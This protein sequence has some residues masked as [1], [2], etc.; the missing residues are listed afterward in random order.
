MF[1]F[2]SRSLLAGP[3]VMEVEQDAVRGHGDD[4]DDDTDDHDDMGDDDADDDH[5]GATDDAALVAAARADPRAFASR[6]ARYVTPVYRYCYL[7]LG[8]PAAA[9]DATGEVFVKALAG[10]PD[11]RDGSFAAWLFRIARNAVA[12]TYRRSRPTVTLDTVGERA[13]R[14]PTP[15]EAML[16]REGLEALRAALDTLPIS[17][18]RAVELQVAGWSLAES[19]AALHVSVGAV[20]LLRYRALGRLKT[21]L[22]RSGHEGSSPPEGDV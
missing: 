2:R 10:L 22:S 17:Q 6:Y 14:D 12:D 20:K 7:R 5:D 16:L 4:H 13:D 8:E 9:E 11:Y 19:A 3:S 18:R 15:D 1:S 21:V